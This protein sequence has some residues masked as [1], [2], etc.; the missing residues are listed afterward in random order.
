MQAVQDR[1]AE[2]EAEV[3]RRAAAL[4]AQNLNPARRRLLS[5]AAKSGTAAQRVLWL[6]R[7]ADL[8]NAAAAGLS[9]CGSGCT[10]C[11]HLG[12]LVSEPEAMV[13]GR[14]IGRAPSAVPEERVM[15]AADSL[16]P[17]DAHEANLAKKARVEEEFLGVPCTFLVGGRCSIYEHR[18]MACRYLINLDV[19]DLL[20]RLVPGETIL[21]RYLNM[22]PQQASYLAIMGFNARIADIREWFPPTVR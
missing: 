22:Q 17:G 2:G 16:E 19:D 5:Q 21:A 18:P 20:C 9:P 6:R 4:E 3:Q 8:V 14:A 15:R 12:T 1:L 11:C 7:E 10:H 13:I